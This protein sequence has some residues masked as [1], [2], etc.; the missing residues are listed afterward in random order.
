MKNHCILALS[1]FTVNKK[2]I[3]GRGNRHLQ[4]E[5]TNN[6]CTLVEEEIPKRG[7]ENALRSTPTTQKV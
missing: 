3:N 7:L 6:S 5:A 2:T 4:E 1:L